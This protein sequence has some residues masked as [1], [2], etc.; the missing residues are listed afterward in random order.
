MITQPPRSTLSSSSA[1]SDVYKRQVFEG[2][3]DFLS[4]LTYYKTNQATCDT[5]VLNGV[6]FIERFIELMPKYTKINLYLDNDKAGIETAARIQD[7]RPDAVNRS[8]IIYP[9]Y[10]DFNEYIT[11]Q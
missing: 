11:T 9:Q 6:G 10:K 7:I 4:G 2:F 5:I 8:Q 3:M 1:A